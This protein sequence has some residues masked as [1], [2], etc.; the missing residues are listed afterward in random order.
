[1]SAPDF[2]SN[3]GVTGTGTEIKACP[4]GLPWQSSASTAG[5]TGSI[6]ARE[7][8]ILQVARHGQKT[9]MNE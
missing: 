7:T 8:K 4:L 5:D 9:G 1:M 3:S 2:G 6:P